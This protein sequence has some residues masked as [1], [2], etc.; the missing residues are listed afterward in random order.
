MAFKSRVL[1]GVSGRML[2]RA[3]QKGVRAERLLSLPNWTDLNNTSQTIEIDA[4]KFREQWMLAPG[5]VVA[6]Y[7]G[8]LGAKHGLDLLPRAARMLPNV[9]FVI[10]GDGVMKGQLQRETV[11]LPNVIHMPLQPLDHLQALLSAAD[12]HLLPQ[13]DGAED[14]VMPSKL[15]GMMASGR[16]TVA[17]CRQNTEIAKTLETCGTVVPPGDDEAF[18]AAVHELAVDETLRLEMGARARVFAEANMGRQQILRHLL[19]EL[20]RLTGKPGLIAE[21]TF[22]AESQ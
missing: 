18:V 5:H 1:A 4:K 2:Q 16:P 22:S 21:S 8:S 10:C 6:L 7:S 20:G 11:D 19:V 14:L 17:T 12:I 9:Q 3:A 13:N 15:A